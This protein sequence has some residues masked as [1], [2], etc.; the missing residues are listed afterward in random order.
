MNGLYFGAPFDFERHFETT[1]RCPDAYVAGAPSVTID[2]R[3]DQSV[4]DLAAAKGVPA[5][6]GKQAVRSAIPWQYVWWVLAHCPSIPCPAPKTGQQSLAPYVDGV[7][8]YR[9]DP[10]DRLGGTDVT[11]GDGLDVG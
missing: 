3:E 7:G 5:S 9:R 6:W 4:G 1:F 2:V 11:P 8:C 10:T